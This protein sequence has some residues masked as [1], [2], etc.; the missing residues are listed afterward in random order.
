MGAE[1]VAQF[2]ITVDRK[3]LEKC[4]KNYLEKYV[5]EKLNSTDGVPFFG[6][7]LTEKVF[8]HF[9]S[10][11]SAFHHSK[12]IKLSLSHRHDDGQIDDQ[13]IRAFAQ[14]APDQFAM[15]QAGKYR[16]RFWEH[17][18]SWLRIKKKLVLD[19]FTVEKSGTA[20]TSCLYLSVPALRTKKSSIFTH[21]NTKK[22]IIL[23][24][25]PTE[26]SSYMLLCES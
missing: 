15:W 16:L 13:F 23:E 12:R 4:E 25:V 18:L 14:C 11:S 17:L 21:K 2:P 24:V 22:I 9:V 5:A 10:S 3:K 8:E 20:S 6:Y 26:E 7:A 19:G 1:E